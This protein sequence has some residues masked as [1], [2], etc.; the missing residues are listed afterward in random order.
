VNKKWGCYESFTID[1][2]TAHQSECFYSNRHCPWSGACGTCA[3]TGDTEELRRHLTGSH[4]DVTEEVPNGDKLR[5]TR[6]TYGYKTLFPECIIATLGELFI[7]RASFI[8]NNFYCI[9]QYVGPKNDASRY[10]YKVSISR[11]E[12]A[13][14][15]SVSHVVS[16]DTDDL[17]KI[18]ETGDCVRIPCDLVK[19]YCTNGDEEVDRCSLF[20]LLRYSVK[21]SEI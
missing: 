3:W 15:I 5:L 9:V 14:K 1:D 13:E 8:D 6:T 4:A 11:K 7:H 19:P 10:K 20:P 18:R 12:G 16:N 2:I 21:I 17:H